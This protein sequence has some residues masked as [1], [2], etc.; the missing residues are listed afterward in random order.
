MAGRGERLL[1]ALRGSDQHV[2]PSPHA[3]ADEHGL[4]DLAQSLRQV[5]MAWT[6]SPGGSL[7]M[8]EEL[9]SRA[10]SPVLLDLAGVVRHVEEQSEI[11]IREEVREDLRA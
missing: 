2:G 5:W 10:V 8:H 7:A 4:S 1:F 11:G 9:A 6:K 3:A